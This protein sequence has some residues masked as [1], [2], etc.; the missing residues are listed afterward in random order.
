MECLKASGNVQQAD[1]VVRGFYTDERRLQ[2][3]LAQKAHLDSMAM[4][5]SKLV[6]ENLEFNSKKSDFAPSIYGDRLVFASTRD[7]LKA[8]GEIY[9][10]NQQPYLD[11]Y[12]TEPKAKG[13]VPE[14]F[15]D[16]LES[17]FHDSNLA[18]SWDSQT[19]YFTRNYLKKDKLSA[20]SEGLSNMQIL[21]GTIVGNSLMNVTSLSF[22]SKDYSCGH[23]AVSKNGRYLYFT[24]D[25]PGGFGES[26]IYVVELSPDGEAFTPP[27][28]LGSTVNTPGREMFPFVSNDV[29]YFSS[30]SHYGMGGLDVFASKIFSRSEYSLP[31]NVGKPINSNM[32]DFSYIKSNE[33]Y[34]GYVASNR[35]GGMGDDD[36]YYFERKKPVDCLEYSGYVLNEITN[37]PIPMASVELYNPEDGLRAVVKTDEKGFYQFNLPCKK[38][39]RMVFFKPKHSK[40][41]VMV[42]TMENPQAASSN[43]LVYL[44]PFDS[45]VEKDG[46]VEKIKVDPIYFDYDKSNITT[47]AEIELE[48][49]LFAMKEFPDIKIKIESHTDSR[50]SDDYNLS[51]SDDRAKSTRKY[52]IAKG[53]DIDRIESAN[54]YG[55]YRLK[56]DCGNSVRCSEQDHYVNRRS[57]F[58]IVSK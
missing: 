43:N 25:M 21:K 44:T 8:N 41:T 5:E 26:D 40:K 39:N 48:K 6:L 23:P 24:S 17:S 18:F 28:N 32:D 56:N 27:I 45:L 42:K 13:F 14:K 2:M 11:V 22:N 35:S 29:L 12:V 31:L 7:S 58:I 19:V 34:D 16:N 37:E 10:W 38:N 4:E 15:L 57:D 55:E 52:L 9:P 53:I 49:V 50:G 51:L 47:R 1:D 3:I 33:T 54:G 36:I 30:D 20:N 46:D